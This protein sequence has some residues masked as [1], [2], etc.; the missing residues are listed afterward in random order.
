MVY[1]VGLPTAHGKQGKWPKKIPVR[2]N[3][4]NLEILPKHR[5]NTGNLFFPSCNFPD[6]KGKRYFDIF[7]S[8][9]IQFCGCNSHKSCK[10]AQGKFAVGQGKNRENTGKTQG[11]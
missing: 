8:L 3:T 1:R 7:Y 9:P 5:E 6:S 4:G 2:E 11:I 10:L